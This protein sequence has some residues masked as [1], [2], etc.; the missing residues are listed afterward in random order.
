MSLKTNHGIW[1]PDRDPKRY[2]PH[3]VASQISPCSSPLPM[4]S[5]LPDS[6]SLHPTAQSSGPYARSFSLSSSSLIPNSQIRSRVT[7]VCA[8][9]R[10]CPVQLSPLT[11]FQCKRLKL[12]CDRR[13]PCG[14]CTK[15][16]TVARCVYSPAAAEKV[17]VPLLSL[18]F[19]S[20]ALVATCTPSITASS[21]S[22]PSSPSLPLQGPALT[23]STTTRPVHPLWP[24]GPSSQSANQAPLLQYPS[25]TLPPYGLT[26]STLPRTFCPLNL[27]LPIRL[28]LPMHPAP[29]RSNQ[30]QPRFPPTTLPVPLTLPCISSCPL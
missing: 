26:N 2:V 6:Q 27:P 10:P 20:H 22:S 1:G 7:V 5:S 11:P 21:K 19:L 28:A 14:S 9:V 30:H 8:E 17:S 25:T 29:S 24:I 23:I 13:T 4:E 3:I 16:D 12:K 18:L 15:R